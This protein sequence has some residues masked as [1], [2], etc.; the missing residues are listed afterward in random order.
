MDKIIVCII[1]C[2]F[3]ACSPGKP[4]QTVSRTPAGPGGDTAGLKG[5]PAEAQGWYI[6]QITPKEADRTKVLYAVAQGFSP[7]EAAMEWLVNGKHVSSTSPVQFK[8]MDAVKGDTVQVKAVFQ[9]KEILSDGVMIRNTPPDIS[10]ITIL[11]EIFKPGDTLSVEASGSD[12]DGDEVDLTYEWT[13]NGQPAGS[14]KQIAGT[15]KRGDQVSV[16]ITPFDGET[17]GRP[18]TLYREI[19]NLPPMVI[20][21]NNFVIKDN[22]Y[23]YQVR[24][25]DPDG[26][27][28]SYSLKSG[29]QG[30]TVNESTGRIEW[31]VPPTYQGRASYAVL[32]SDGHGGEAKADF[33]FEARPQSSP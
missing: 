26:D 3:V 11:P 2:F 30:M 1:L 9:G 21:D 27:A 15:L 28:L 32:V 20:E 17:Y 22:V 31:H 19:R 5:G 8:A 16:T 13:K 6:L 4:A 29:P 7:S 23:T 12:I 33:V 10:R 25:S 14:A 18:V 24:A